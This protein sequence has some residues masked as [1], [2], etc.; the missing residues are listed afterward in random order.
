MFH[1]ILGAWDHIFILGVCRTSEGEYALSEAMPQV[2]I[3]GFPQRF[4][5]VVLLYF[6]LPINRK[7][8]QFQSEWV[9][10]F[11]HFLI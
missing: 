9:L 4:M 11:S 1:G 2:R 8:D 3:I 7:L 6:F 5:D 10:S